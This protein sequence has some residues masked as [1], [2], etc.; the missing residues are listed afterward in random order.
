MDAVN[1]S[2]LRELSE[3]H[4]ISELTVIGAPAGGF[5]VRV[6][7]GTGPHPLIKLLGTS[8]GAIRRYASLDTAATF[9]R[10]LGIERFEVDLNGY[11]PGLVRAPRPDRAE[12]L[13]NTR[14]TP[15]QGDLLA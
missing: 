6:T 1:E 9:I 11:R 15:R 13:R 10:Q 14:T 2:T 5:A 7:Y 12:A 4:A 3:A 8:R